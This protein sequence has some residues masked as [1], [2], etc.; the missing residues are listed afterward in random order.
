MTVCFL[1]QNTTLTLVL[2]LNVKRTKA[3][4]DGAADNEAVVG[5]NKESTLETFLVS[6]GTRT[7]ADPSPSQAQFVVGK[8]TIRRPMGLAE[9]HNIDYQCV[10]KWGTI[11]Y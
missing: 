5:R 7:L 10:S 4:A 3:I 9:T 8:S 1:L 11:R 6:R 2:S